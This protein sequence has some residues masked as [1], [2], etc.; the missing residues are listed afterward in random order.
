MAGKVKAKITFALILTII[1][2]VCSFAVNST[3]AEAFASQRAPSAPKDTTGFYPWSGNGPTAMAQLQNYDGKGWM[4]IN[5]GCVWR[6]PVTLDKWVAAGPAESY[7]PGLLSSGGALPAITGTTQYDSAA[8]YPWTN[9]GPKTISMQADNSLLLINSYSKAWSLKNGA[10]V[11]DGLLYNNPAWN[12]AEVLGGAYAPYWLNSPSSI[13]LLSDHATTLVINSGYFWMLSSSGAW[14]SGGRL[15]SNWFGYPQDGYYPTDNEGPG[16]VTFDS[17]SNNYLITNMGMFWV[18]DSSG[19]LLFKGKLS[20]A[21]SGAPSQATECAA[22]AAHVSVPVVASLS[23]TSPQAYQVFQRDSKLSATIPVTGT[24][25]AAGDTIR[26][27]VLNSDRATVASQEVSVS[28]AAA[29]SAFSSS[30]YV[31]TGSGWYSLLVEE[32]SNSNII[33]SGEISHVG[34]GEVFI[35]AGQ[36]NTVNS[37]DLFSFTSP[38]M[39]STF[40]PASGTWAQAAIT[41]PFAQGTGSAPWAY[42]GQLLSAHINVPVAILTLGEG[43]TAISQWVPGTTLYSRLLT[44]TSAMIARGGFRAILWHQ[45]ETDTAGGTSSGTYYTDFKTIHDGLNT[46]TSATLTWFV[47][48]ASYFPSN[49]TQ[50]SS[51]TSYQTYMDAI[52]YAQQMT[53]YSSPFLAYPGPDTDQW[54]GATYRSNSATGMCVHFNKTGI[55]THAQGWYSAVIKVLNW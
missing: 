16:A 11:Y 34:V 14:S 38:A 5:Q 6:L 48:N 18:L 19:A 43:G 31:P 46:Q 52:R 22:A 27:Q 23:V 4:I 39:V 42:F 51:T 32:L 17:V 50:C 35:T 7:L 49:T 10:V 15:G 20:D 26:V 54:S 25:P 29:G 12:Q 13:Y 28:G 2:L 44:G 3:P 21:W 37:G 33:A 41:M 8:E 36:S 30:L 1:M 45:G 47:A 53:W 40:D 9:Y 24:L 55:L